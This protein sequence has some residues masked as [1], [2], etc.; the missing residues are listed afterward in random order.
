MI[1][2][3]EVKSKAYTVTCQRCKDVSRIRIINDTQVVYIDQVPIISA[4]LRGDMNWG[5]ECICGNDSRVAPEEKDNLN[6]LVQMHD[7]VRKEL[8]INQIAKTLTTKNHLKFRM[9]EA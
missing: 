2:N 1:M 7:P 5:F 8:T 3:P 9:V 6:F 4:R